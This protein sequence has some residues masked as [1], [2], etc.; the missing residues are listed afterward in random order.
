[1]HCYVENRWYK[2]NMPKAYNNLYCVQCVL[3]Q[4]IHDSDQEPYYQAPQSKGVDLGSV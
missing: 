3:E 2:L 1:M 4:I